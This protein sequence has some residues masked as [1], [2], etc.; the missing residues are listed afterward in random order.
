[1]RATSTL[2]DGEVIENVGGNAVPGTA[3]I[4][5]S[6]NT[7]AYPAN[8]VVGGLQ[9]F[10]SIGPNGAEIAVIGTSLLIGSSAL[11]SGEGA[12]NLHLYNAAPPSN[13]ADNTVWDIPAGDRAAY[14][15]FVP[16]GTPVS[17][18]SSLWIEQTGGILKMLSLLG[19]DLWA[20][21][22]TVGGYTPTSG[23]LYMPTIHT[24]VAGT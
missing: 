16:M 22:V 21:L 1:M 3:T 24:A 6:L 12:Y 2:P 19:N 7:T 20:Y 13:Y 15:G 9:H 4:N 23:R 5:R 8:S 14:L 11:I 10:P 18:G 17:L